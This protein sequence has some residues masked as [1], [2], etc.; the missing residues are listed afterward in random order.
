MPT[1][2]DTSRQDIPRR[3]RTLG[4]V[5]LAV[6]AAG[7]GRPLA[8]QHEFFSPLSGNADRIGA[9]ASHA[10][11]HHRALH[12]AHRECGP[13][14]SGSVAWSASDR[15][16]GGPDPGTTAADAALADL[17]DTPARPP[18]AAHGATSNAY[19]RWVEDNVREL[20]A[21]SETA[22]GAAGGS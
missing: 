13:P 1:L 9:Q 21:A 19:R 6:L 11:S 15:A 14:P 18:V 22:A 8:V 17:C 4:A 2:H 12:A 10:V 7:C 5:L 3:L 16:R 20:P